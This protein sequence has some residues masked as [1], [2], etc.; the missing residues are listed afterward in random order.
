[1]AAN[2]S[3]N[4]WECFVDRDADVRRRIEQEETEARLFFRQLEMERSAWS[5]DALFQMDRDLR[6]LRTNRNSLMLAYEDINARLRDHNLWMRIQRDRLRARFIA[7]YRFPELIPVE[8]FHPPRCKTC[9]MFFTIQD[10]ANGQISICTNC[11]EIR[12]NNC[13]AMRSH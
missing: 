12:C 1:M 4:T 5:S 7:P 8:P 2:E 10:A 3:D 13:A 11:S 6:N 9:L